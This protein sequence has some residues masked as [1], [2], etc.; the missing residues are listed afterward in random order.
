MTYRT[1]LV[2]V[3]SDSAAAPRL[4]AAAAIARDFDATLIGLGAETVVWV[5]AGDPSGMMSSDLMT[6]MADQAQDDLTAAGVLFEQHAA[7][8]RHSWLTLAEPPAQAMARVAR[9]ADLLIAGGGPL[10]GSGSHRA[11]DT[12]DLVLLSGRPV[13]VAPPEGGRLRAKQI[14]VAWRDSR[15]ARRAVADAL[16]FLQRAEEVVVMEVCD[17]DEFRSAQFRTSDVAQHL[18]QHGVAA[19]GLARI[20]VRERAATELNIEAQA[21]GADLIVSGAYGHNRL[22]EWVLGGVTRDFLLQ[23]ERFLL[24]S[25]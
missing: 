5:G 7:S 21:I 4:A 16:P 22:Q 3:E 10:D 1:L 9:A 11:A 8:A 18:K 20:A 19:R 25:H 24:L 13:L 2:H 23:P 17:P 15:E 14:V 12:V 6:L